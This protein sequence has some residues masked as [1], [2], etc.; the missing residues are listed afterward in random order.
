MFYL[1]DP[2]TGKPSPTTTAFVVGF[3]VAVSK[4][5]FSGMVIGAFTLSPFTGVDFAASVGALGAI[6][7]M[8]DKRAAKDED[9]QTKI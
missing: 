9:E 6:Y 1:P 3:A 7:V 8:R 2:N 5:L 4:L